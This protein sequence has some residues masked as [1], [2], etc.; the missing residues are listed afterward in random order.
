MGVVNSRIYRLMHFMFVE[1]RACEDLH[2]AQKIAD[3]MHNV[4]MMLVNDRTEEAILEEIKK[5]AERCG[6]WPYISRYIEHV[7]R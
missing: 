1:I 4:P 2:M 3:V 7:S 6:N 5:R